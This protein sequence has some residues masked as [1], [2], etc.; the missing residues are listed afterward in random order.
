MYA[1]WST[2]TT[3]AIPVDVV[4]AHSA[5]ID[6]GRTLWRA[7]KVKVWIHID[8]TN[9]IILMLSKTATNN[10]P[11][12]SNIHTRGIVDCSNAFYNSEQGALLSCSHSAISIII[13]HC[14]WIV[15]VYHG[16][17][18]Y[19][20]KLVRFLAYYFH[21]VSNFFFSLSILP[22]IYWC[23]IHF[24]YWYRKPDG[25]FASFFCLSFRY[26][27]FSNIIWA[28]CIFERGKCYD[29]QAEHSGFK[30]IQS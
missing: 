30:F 5:R 15:V 1:P 6:N 10:K 29:M 13:R 7:H 20:F 16:R 24:C 4:P 21:F 12:Y 9:H 3:T 27:N 2:R 17:S 26:G 23:F 22:Y 25:F 8:G 19:S 11:T 28:N 18:M 14:S